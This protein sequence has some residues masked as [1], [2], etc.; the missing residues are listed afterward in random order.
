MNLNRR[1]YTLWDWPKEFQTSPL[2]YTMKSP[3][4]SNMTTE[5][6][7]IE[8]KC[9]IPNYKKRAVAAV[10]QVLTQN[11]HFPAQRLFFHSSGDLI[12]FIYLLYVSLKEPNILT[13]KCFFMLC[14]EVERSSKYFAAIYCQRTS[15]CRSMLLRA[16]FR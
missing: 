11:L 12:Q 15:R 7:S 1:I 13:A 14:L 2:L 9:N 16:T 10:L 8:S 3:H 4:G 6:Q 5:P